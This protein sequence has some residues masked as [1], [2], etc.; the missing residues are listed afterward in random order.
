V[1]DEKMMRLSKQ[2][3][4]TLC[5]ALDNRNWDYDKDDENLL[6]YFGVSG[7][8]M[9]IRVIITIDTERQLIRLTACPP[10]K[11][12]EEK[13]LEGAI[14]AC[15]VSYG[16]ADGSFDY[17]FYDGTIAFRMTQTFRDSQI[18]EEF[19]QYMISCA[20]VM[21]DRYSDKFLALDKGAITIADFIT[22][23]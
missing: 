14:A 2:V 19:F 13:R 10:F 9:A 8:S 18:G 15:F 21:V 3:Y 11:M 22:K 12:S 7:D 16:M 6:V 5:E 4:Q 17:N 20:C 23:D 1:A